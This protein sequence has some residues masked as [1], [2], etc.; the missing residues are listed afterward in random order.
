V[1]DPEEVTARFQ[2]EF[3]KLVLSLLLG[4]WLTCAR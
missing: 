1:P 2:Q 4:P 3:E